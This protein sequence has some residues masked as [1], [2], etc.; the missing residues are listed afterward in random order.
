MNENFGQWYT[1]IVINA[2]LIDYSGVRGCIIL[3]PYGYA[4]WENITKILDNRFKN[5]GVENVA[6]PLLI[7]ES[8]LEKE[9][10]HI[11]G[12]APEVAWVTMGG[13][14]KLTERL[15][16]RPTSE[17]LFCSHFAKIIHSWRDLPKLY[18]QWCSV[19]RWEKTS[20]PF[21]RSIEFYWQE[22]HA[23]FAEKHE[24]KDFTLKMLKVYA[25]FFKDILCIPVFIGQKTE[26]EKF[27]GAEETYTIECMMKDGKALQSATSHYFGTGFS[28]AFDIVFQDKKNKSSLVSYV[29]WGLA[30]RVIGGI[31]MVHGDN[32]GLIMPPDVAP[33]QI[34][35][36]P[37]KYEENNEVFKKS[38]EIFENL[39]KD[40]RVKIDVSSQTP[41]WK[42]SEYEMKGVPIRLE[43]GPKDIE[44]NQCVLARRDSHEKIKCNLDV[45]NEELRK[46]FIKIKLNLYLKA[47][48]FM[49]SKVFSAKNWEEMLNL[50]NSNGFLKTFWCGDKQCEE[51]V[52]NELGL[53]SRCMPLEQNEIE[54]I[55]PICNKR[56]AITEIFWGKSY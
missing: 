21:L 24:A 48:K 6:M 22:G 19:V 26:S 40:F 55:C 34:I 49:K 46:I 50:K 37:I 11:A 20:R 43:I 54:G 38:N 5:V 56:P 33:I 18:N 15:C 28:N 16:I 25:D 23:V 53:S 17:V 51:K 30:T 9:K 44:K 3:R 8:L 10:N 52:K 35:I 2:E 41:G 14:E 13:Q 7:P 31:I 45:L 27:A 12:F 4:I 42:F 32:N 29:S 47:E 36:I 39:K 1:D